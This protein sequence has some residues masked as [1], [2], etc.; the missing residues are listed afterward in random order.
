[1]PAVL[2]GEGK[3]NKNLG[4]EPRDMV[5]V[6]RSPRGANTVLQ[7]DLDGT[8]QMAMI[9]DYQVHP[10][11][12]KLLHAD[13]L[14]VS[15]E[16]VL[17][18]RVPLKFIGRSKGEDIGGRIMASTRE[19]KLRC[20]VDHIPENIEIDVTGYELGQMLYSKDMVFPDGVEPAYRGNFPIFTISIPRVMEE[21]VADEE[22]EEGEGGEGATTDDAAKTTET[23]EE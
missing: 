21:E 16:N 22:G 7:L 19:L 17:V 15:P 5:R 11:K 13:F 18:V 4:V 1:V 14:R 8:Q 9:R 3:E 6:L 2:Y 23:A 12:R 20:R 10:V